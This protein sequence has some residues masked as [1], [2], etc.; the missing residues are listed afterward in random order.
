MNG[1]DM[2]RKKL[3]T[4]VT[5]FPVVLDFLDDGGWNVVIIPPGM[6]KMGLEGAKGEGGEITSN[7]VVDC[8]DCI[9]AVVSMPSWAELQS[10]C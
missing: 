9:V 4:F 7:V 8:M 3:C 1:Y 10:V 2:T 5:R 6:G